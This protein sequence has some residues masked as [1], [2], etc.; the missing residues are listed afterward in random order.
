MELAGSLPDVRLRAS[1]APARGDGAGRRT[2][3]LHRRRT[4][5]ASSAALLLRGRAGGR[6]PRGWPARRGGC[7]GGLR[8]AGEVDEEK[9]GRRRT[10]RGPRVAYTGTSVR[11]PQVAVESPSGILPEPLPS[12]AAGVSHGIHVYRI[13][14]RSRCRQSKALFTSPFQPK[15]FLL[16]PIT[17]NLSTHA[18]SIKCR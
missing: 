10:T 2:P 5:L 4:F 16:P 3:L 18:W 17:S 11:P 15:I 8:G 9:Q 13:V 1:A 7:A 14:Y 6:T 12:P